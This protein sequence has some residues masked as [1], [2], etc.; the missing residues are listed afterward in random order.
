[1][2]AAVVIPVWRP[3]LG[4]DET[5]S[6]RRCLSVLGTHSVTLIAPEGLSTDALPLAGAT[7]I[8][9]R[10]AP[11]FFHGIDGYNRLMLSADFYG[12]F[13]AYDYILLHQLDAF[14]FADRLA[15]WCARGYDYVGA[16]WIGDGW[17]EDM[18]P[19]KRRLLRAITS[20]RTRVGNGGFSL[21][22]VSSFQRA[23]QRLRPIVRRWTSNEDL[24]WSVVARRAASFR[25]PLAAEA[26]TFAFELEPRRCYEELGRTLPFGCHAWPRYDPDFWRGVFASLGV[27]APTSVP[28]GSPA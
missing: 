22:R 25:I 27:A 1:M 18:S 24:F 14:V 23:L 12:R 20:P 8:V 19:L 13:A 26:M 11:E 28:R 5:L 10:F 3:T 21:R 9:E 2:K 15:D 16:P 7:P 17:P 4:P 6:L